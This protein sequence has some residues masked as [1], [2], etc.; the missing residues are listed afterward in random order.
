MSC[1]NSAGARLIRSRPRLCS[2]LLIAA[3]DLRHLCRALEVAGKDSITINLQNEI[4]YE[5]NS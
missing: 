4:G 5:S 2:D 3:R 1:G